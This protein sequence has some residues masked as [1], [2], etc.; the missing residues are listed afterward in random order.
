M[1]KI[2]T[3]GEMLEYKD[4]VNDAY[5]KV[6]EQLDKKH[7]NDIC[8]YSMNVDEDNNIYI[9]IKFKTIGD[10]SNLPTKSDNFAIVYHLSG[11]ARIAI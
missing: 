3:F 6:F 7:Q 5:D 4:A 2:M 9:T 1:K 10:F 8:G 11:Q